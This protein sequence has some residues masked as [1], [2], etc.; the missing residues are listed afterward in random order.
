MRIGA[1]L[2]IIAVGAILKFAVTK[3]VSGVNLGTV[4]IVLMIVGAVGL[5]IS[6]I[7][8]TSRRR[9]DVVHHHNGTTYVEPAD[10]DLPRY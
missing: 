9:T 5:V 2:L 3:Q 4:G 7:L 6:L 10:P 1:S 8:M